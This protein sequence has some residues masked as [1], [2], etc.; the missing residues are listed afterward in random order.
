MSIVNISNRGSTYVRSQYKYPR[1]VLCWIA[2]K[3]NEAGIEEIVKV[4]GLEENTRYYVGVYSVTESYRSAVSNVFSVITTV[5]NTP[6]AKLQNFVVNYFEGEDDCLE[7]QFQPLSD[8]T[9]YDI[10]VNGA[11][12]W[13]GASGGRV[14]L[15]GFGGVEL[16]NVHSNRPSLFQ[17]GHQI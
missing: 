6:P 9:F 13:S 4:D 3:L 7:I 1:Y 8:T 2:E 16:S 17:E 15:C 14:L 10:Y 12:V 5:D 11:I